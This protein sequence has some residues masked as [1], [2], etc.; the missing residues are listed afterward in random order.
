M[1]T[2]KTIAL[3]SSSERAASTMSGYAMLIALVLVILMQLFGIINL[4]NDNNSSLAVWS[5]IVGPILLILIA[6]GF[7][8]LQPNQAAAITLFGDYRGTDRTT[9]LRWT[10]RE[11]GVESRWG[12]GYGATAWQNGCR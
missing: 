6:P 8:M 3:N 5:V 7:Y 2:E 10:W 11:C 12:D 4:A 1:A 9:G